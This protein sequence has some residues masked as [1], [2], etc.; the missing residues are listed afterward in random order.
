VTFGP[1]VDGL[2]LAKRRARCRALR[3]LALLILNDDLEAW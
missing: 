2:D 1:L 3:A